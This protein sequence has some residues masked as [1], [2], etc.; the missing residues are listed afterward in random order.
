MPE[1][2]PVDRLEVLVLVENTTDSLSSNPENVVP[3]WTGLLSTGRIETLAGH[4]ICHAQHGLS[5]LIRA[6]RKG[7]RHALLLDAGPEGATLLRNA[8]LLGAGFEDVEAVVLSHG[9]WDHGGGLVEA[10]EAV[11]T[12]RGRETFDCYVHPGMFN[13]RAARRPDGQIR[14][15]AP[16]PGPRE[17]AHAGAR[18]VSTREPQVA[19]N[20]WFYV[21]G[22][23]PRRTA[24]EVGIPGNLR[25][26]D[27]GLAWEDDPLIV[28]ERFVSVHVAGK[29]Q[30]VFSACS[31]AGLVN[32][33]HEARARFPATPLYGAMGGLHLAGVTEKAIPETVRDLGGFGLTMLAAGH[34]TGWRAM[35]ALANRFGE[36]LVPLAV[37]KKYVL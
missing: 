7:E 31:H 13:A 11:A 27:D 6:E 18:V 25:R 14:F 3:E 37:G 22:E 2:R 32:V 21:S 17:L 10:I 20:G 26:S 33:L 23:I 5:L 29:G 36:A 24:Y 1:V 34:C 35:S 12:A 8:E 28:D 4:D 15:T 30:F 16:I 9:H 19:G